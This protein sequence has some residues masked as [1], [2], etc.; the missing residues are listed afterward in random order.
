MVIPGRILSSRNVILEQKVLEPLTPEQDVGL[1]PMPTTKPAVAAAMV[2][3]ST[4]EGTEED[5][6][7]EVVEPGFTDVEELTDVIE[8]DAALIGDTLEGSVEP[9]PDVDD[10][11]PAGEKTVDS[12]PLAGPATAMP[13]LPSL[14][15]LGSSLAEALLLNEDVFGKASA[16]KIVAKSKGKLKFAGTK[17]G[18]YRLSLTNL[19]DDIAS[20]IKTALK[21]WKVKPV[22]PGEKESLSSKYTTYIVMIDRNKVPVVFS[23]GKNEGQ[24]FEAKLKTGIAAKKGA[25][26]T[27]VMTALNK[28]YGI[29]DTDIAG[30]DKSAGGNT[31]VKR[32]FADKLNNIGP[33]VTD[34][35]LKLV[36]PALIGGVK[37]SEIYVSIKNVSGATIAN[38]GYSDAFVTLPTRGKRVVIEARPSAASPNTD[39]F[40][41]ILGVDKDQIARGL[42][43]Y[44][45]KIVYTDGMSATPAIDK[46]AVRLFLAAQLGYGYVYL[47]E[48]KAGTLKIVN[49]SSADK[50]LEFIGEVQTVVVTYPYYQDSSARGSRKQCTAKITTT[51]AVYDVE[52][53]N[54]SGG[55]GKLMQC[56]IRL[57]KDLST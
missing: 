10:P 16:M 43:A 34:M 9:E 6:S 48:Q 12:D 3:G 11:D 2:D 30:V 57:V 7:V 4:P 39:K 44:A 20:V 26:W 28:F 24:K 38:T 55:V 41:A 45:N 49:L 46:E 37:Q 27:A 51:K 31:R 29:K 36:K 47:R 21:G 40:M 8:D 42:T 5:G 33:L 14:P 50:A 25:A 52:I 17:R 56:N 53:R 13:S 1:A 35:T 18:G 19:K 32:P 23:A 54:A 22:A 15:S